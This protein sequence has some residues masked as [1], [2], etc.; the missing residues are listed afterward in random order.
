MREIYEGF[1]LYC[2]YKCMVEFFGSHKAILGGPDALYARLSPHPGVTSAKPVFPLC[3]MPHWRLDERFVWRCT[4]GVGQFF[5]IR[6][7]FAAI[8]LVLGE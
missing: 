7:S 4:F 1:V 2:F 8:N 5:V 6:V 3:F